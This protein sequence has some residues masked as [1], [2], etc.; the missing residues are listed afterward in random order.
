MPKWLTVRGVDVKRIAREVIEMGAVF[1]H[2][3]VVPV[4]YVHWV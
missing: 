4:G 2:L 1:Y 3:A